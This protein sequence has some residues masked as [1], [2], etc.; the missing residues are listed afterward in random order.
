[1]CSSGADVVCLQEAGERSYETDFDFLT[2]Q[3][4]DYRIIAKGRMRCITF[5][6][7]D[8]LSIAPGG[9]AYSKVSCIKYN[10]STIIVT[11]YCLCQLI[12]API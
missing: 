4:F 11:L 7:A 9:D 5:W 10:L 12:Y 2:E 8:R 1:M 3:G 6:K